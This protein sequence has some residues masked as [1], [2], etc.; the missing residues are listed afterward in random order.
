MRHLSEKVA[1]RFSF[2][3]ASFSK[4]PCTF[5]PTP[6]S[7]SQT[8]EELQKT[9][10]RQIIQPQRRFGKEFATPFAKKVRTS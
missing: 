8:A 7:L 10:R 9:N 5:F 6:P 4:K 2:S 1:H 3:L